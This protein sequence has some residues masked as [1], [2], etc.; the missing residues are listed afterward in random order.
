MPSVRASGRLPASVTHT[1]DPSAPDRLR[2]AYTVCCSRIP[3]TKRPA[4]AEMTLDNP[5]YGLREYR[6]N[7][8]R[9]E[10]RR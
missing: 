5:L 1:A 2:S 7:L 4:P 9:R 3:A 6:R 8:S 10:S